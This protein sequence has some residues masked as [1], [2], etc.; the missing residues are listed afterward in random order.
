M[1]SGQNAEQRFDM[2]FQGIWEPDLLEDDDEDGFGRGWGNVDSCT[3]A[4]PDGIFSQYDL[5]WPPS[6]S[7][8]GTLPTPALLESL[9]S[10]SIPS[11]LQS[12]LSPSPAGTVDTPNNSLQLTMSTPQKLPVSHSSRRLSRY[13]AL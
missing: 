9:S 4:S 13:A 12:T 3:S 7:F 1:T 5:M 8:E 2:P 11:Q 6:P 10:D